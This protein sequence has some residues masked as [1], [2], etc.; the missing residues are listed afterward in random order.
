MIVDD[1]TLE[2]CLGTGAY[3]EVYLT[4]KKGSS[5]K[6]ATKR[7]DKKIANSEKYQKYFKNERE[8]L[9]GIE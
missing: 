7:I 8:I 6:F 2:K 1:L 5:Q 3:G 9:K 4:R